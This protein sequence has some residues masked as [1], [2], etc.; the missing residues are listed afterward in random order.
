MEYSMAKKSFQLSRGCSIA[1]VCSWVLIFLIGVCL[2]WFFQL[3]DGL[4]SG[5]GRGDQIANIV[6]LAESGHREWLSIFE[7]GKAVLSFPDQPGIFSSAPPITLTFEEWQA[8]KA[9]YQEWCARPP[10]RT[11]E[12]GVPVYAMGLSCGTQFGRYIVVPETQVPP[13]VLRLFKRAATK[14][15]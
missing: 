8:F 3:P 5:L 9:V 6:V 4:G 15:P 2:F 11:D 10:L 14:Q 13:I 7:N 12:V 1:L